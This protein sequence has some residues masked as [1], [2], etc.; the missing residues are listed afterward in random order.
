ME[1]TKYLC[2]IR[3]VPYNLINIDH[4]PDHFSLN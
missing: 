3:T 4:D 2:Y 1:G